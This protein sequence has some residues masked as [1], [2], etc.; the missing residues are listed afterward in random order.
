MC[1]ENIG[2]YE[3]MAKIIFQLSSNTHRI[4]SSDFTVKFKGQCLV[5]LILIRLIIFIK[6]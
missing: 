2:F 4:S 6:M 1:T 3:E 5:L